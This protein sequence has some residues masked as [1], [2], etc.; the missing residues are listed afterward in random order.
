MDVG[1]A[2]DFEMTKIEQLTSDKVQSAF[3]NVNKTKESLS[4]ISDLIAYWIER[5]DAAEAL[6]IAI[7]CGNHVKDENAVS[8]YF[9]WRKFL[10]DSANQVISRESTNEQ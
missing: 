10:T 8:A 7:D 1:G 2:N 9:K 5:C 3:V 4:V 6:L